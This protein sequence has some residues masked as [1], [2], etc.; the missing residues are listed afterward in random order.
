MLQTA[1]ARRGGGKPIAAAV[2][3]ALTTALLL[4]LAA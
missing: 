1:G 3:L 2:W 4:Q